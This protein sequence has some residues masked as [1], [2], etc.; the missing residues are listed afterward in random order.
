MERTI[1][2]S[3][4]TT[5]G[6][7]V[8]VKKGKI[9]LSRIFPNE[10]QKEGTLTAELK[11]EVHTNSYYPS[12]KVSSDMQDSLFPEAAFGFSEQKFTSVETRVAWVFVPLNI[13]EEAVIA[14]IAEA[15]ANGATIYKVLASEPI[16][17][18]NQQF[19]INSPTIPRTKDSFA[20]TQVARYP[21]GH[22]DEGK[23]I[24][25]T[26][27]N[28]FYRKVYYSSTPQQDIDARDASKLY[29]SPEIKAELQG[30]AVLQGQDIAG[31]V[32]KNF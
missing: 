6:K 27:G 11:Q 19:A 18:E 2:K 30:A 4:P 17:D 9:N 7:R 14:Q 29:M 31:E 1:N 15:E 26:N 32:V 5:S 20:N 12:K 3:K 13:T 25:D 24:L 28:P 10:F 22:P 23:L 16:L 21:M 8:E